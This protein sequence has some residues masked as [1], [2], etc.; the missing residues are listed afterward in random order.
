M[1]RTTTVGKP[2]VYRQTRQKTRV[3]LV[4]CI[5]LGLG[6]S[7]NPQHDTYFPV[8]PQVSRQNL[9]CAMISTRSYYS[10]VIVSAQPISIVAWFNDVQRPLLVSVNYIHLVSSRM[11]WG[12]AFSNVK[13]LHLCIYIYTYL[14]IYIY[15][16][17]VYLYSGYMWRL[18]HLHAHLPM[19]GLFDDDPYK[20]DKVI[21]PERSTVSVHW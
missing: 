10:I 9:P 16:N 3:L 19:T 13:R 18:Q 14:C 4:R 1:V 6:T 21:A 7:A 11:F 5:I 2:E 15:Y 20:G 8:Q 17:L 12:I